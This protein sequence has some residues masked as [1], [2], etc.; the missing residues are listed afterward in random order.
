MESLYQQIK[1][2][3]SSFVGEVVDKKFVIEK[4]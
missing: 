3:V 4:P 1:G 2:I